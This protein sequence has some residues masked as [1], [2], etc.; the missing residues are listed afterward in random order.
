MFRLRPK[1]GK[2]LG[3]LRSYW[4]RLPWLQA[5]QNW[6]TLPLI[7]SRDGDVPRR[8]TSVHHH[9]HQQMVKQRIFE[10][11]LKAGQAIL[12]RCCKENAD[13]LIISNNTQR[14]TLRSFKQGSLA[15]QPPRQCQDKEKYWMQR[16]SMDAA[17][18]FLSLQLI[19][20]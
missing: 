2:I 14:C 5:K 3:S 9:S 8:G 11:Y 12:A 19:N 4:Q 10:L 6:H 16:V 17:A 7:G 18:G 20:Q 1:C 15:V 13:T